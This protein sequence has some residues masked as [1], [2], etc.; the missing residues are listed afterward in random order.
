MISHKFL[1]SLLSLAATGLSIPQAILNQNQVIS[2]VL[3]GSVE[4][5]KGIPF[6]DPP[7]GNLRFKHPTDFSG[8]YQGL[9]ANDFK[10]ACMQL[11]PGGVFTLLDNLIGIGKLIPSDI[12]GPL[13][14]IAQG[15]FGMSEDCLYLNVFRPKGTKST[16]KLPVMAWIYGGGFLIGSTATY[17]GNFYIK[18]SVDMGQPV[19]FVSIAYRTGPY[20]FL[21]GDAATDEGST[22]SGLHD[23]RKALE[24]IQDNIANFGGDPSRV[25]LFGESAGAM[26]VAHQMVAYGGDN[27]YKGNKLFTSAILQSGGPLPYYNTESVGPESAYDRFVKYAGC[28]SSNK[29]ADTLACLRGKSGDVLAAAQNSY[30][31]NDL[32]GILP[33]FLGFG[34]R[35][36]GD[37]IPESSFNLFKSGKVAQVP[38]ITGN[39]EDEGTIF[40]PVALNATTTA[41]VRKWLQYIFNGASDKSIENV[42]NGYSSN[43]IYGAPFR[44]LLLNAITPQFKRMAAIFTDILFQS[45]RRV[46]LE[47]SNQKR[48][49]YLSNQ[50]HVVPVIG[51]FHGSDLIFQYFLSLGPYQ[52]YRRY[53]VAFA[54][55]HDPNVGSGLTNWKEYTNEG[56]DMLEIQYFL[57]TMRKDDFR[58]DSIQYFQDNGELLGKK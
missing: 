7:I 5:F 8:S 32:Y 23:Q 16:D 28:S 43:P 20:G 18:E 40:A 4:T 2:G 52:A 55:N 37:I 36:D 50:L 21:G 6:A 38:F 48:W 35:P 44:T 26:S 57:N 29:G 31:F 47:N 27:T 22:N 19:I 3:E 51:T 34:P 42:L 58:R 56:K 9:K 54:N 15:T 53:F 41:D 24:W 39:M 30:D 45:P 13:Y 11:N 12:R 25:M 10:P 33:E 1:W 17:P 14:D 49:T 46:M